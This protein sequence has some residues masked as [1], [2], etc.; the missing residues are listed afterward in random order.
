MTKKLR[1]GINGFGRIGR[2]IARINHE[3]NLFEL[4]AI[5]DLDPYVDNMAYLLKYDSTFGKF[6]GEVSCTE[7]TLNI[8][9]KSIAYFS[10]ADI[11][12]VPW[13][14]LEVD[15]VIDSS[16]VTDNVMKAK[17]GLPGKVKGV[18][19]THSS[20]N[21]DK[22]IILGINDTTMTKEDFIVSNSI[23]DANAI[24][25][26]MKAIHAEFGIISGS[27]TT[28]HPWLSYQNLTDGPSISRSR[29]GIVWQDYALGRSSV[30]NIIPKNTT[31]MDA[32]E[33]VLPELKGKVLSFS[34]R[35]PTAIVASS[36]ITLRTAK[37]ITRN[38]VLKLFEKLSSE[39]KYVKL[40]HESLVSCDYEMDPHSCVIDA[41]WVKTV[42]DMLK[43]VVWYDNEWAYS[44]RTL[45]LAQKLVSIK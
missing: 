34:Y 8:N 19:V 43:M 7:N 13:N 31:A 40:N 20:Q 12:N 11:S 4:V 38:D 29:P 21:T 1:L 26:V 32:V 16:G 23:C 42:D 6:P 14:D 22:E 30:N 2:T 25:H 27:L 39:S 3:Q 36:D 9:G 24:A 5:N 37:K 41:Q 35:V 10:N 33:K 45:E 15:V 17:K 44:I 28:I 18:V